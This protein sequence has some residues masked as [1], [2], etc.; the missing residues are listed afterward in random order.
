MYIMYINDTGNAIG[1]DS[2]G[3]QVKVI[4]APLAWFSRYVM[5]WAQSVTAGKHR[6][7]YQTPMGSLGEAQ[8]EPEISTNLGF[9]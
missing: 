9:Q 1:S 5:D 3:F 6:P 2:V 4:R 8:L 7:Q